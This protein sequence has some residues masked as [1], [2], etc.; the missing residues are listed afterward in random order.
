ML[1]RGKRE[2]RRNKTT[3]GLLPQFERETLMKDASDMIYKPVAPQFVI[4]ETRN[5]SLIY[6]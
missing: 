5:E 6:L 2:K 3:F 1:K 4:H